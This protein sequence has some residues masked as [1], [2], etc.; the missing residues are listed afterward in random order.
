M[1]G[2]A[3]WLGAQQR[4]NLAITLALALAPALVIGLIA[5]QLLRPLPDIAA[6]TFLPAT[7]RLGAVPPPL[8]W[9]TTGS[10]AVAVTGLGTIGTHGPQT[11]LPLASTAKVMTALVVLAD[12]PLRLTEQGPTVPVSAADVATYVAEK[13]QGQSVFPVAAGEKLS[14][15]QALQAL[16]VPSG[17]NIAELLAAWD[18]GSVGAFVDKMNARAATL[19]LLHTHYVDASGLSPQSVGTPEEL[20]A[21]AEAA[22]QDPV[23]AEIVAQPEATLPVAGRVFNV[24]AV[25]GQDGIVGV[26]TGSS[27]AAGACFVFAAD[28]RADGQPAR[29]FGAILGLPTLDDAFTSATSLVQAVGSALH[30]RSVLSTN[31]V[32]AEYAAPWGD[33][34]TVFAEQDVNWIAYDGMVLRQ[35]TD[36]I[37]VRAPLP[38]GSRV[39]T[40]TLELGEQRTQ[41]PLKT[42]EP[43]FQPDSV[44]RL[45]RVRLDRLFQ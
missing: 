20:I 2:L 30:Y 6:T 36:I 13:N 7:S 23:F 35:R 34:A 28:V 44:W 31:Q 1:K 16:L 12:R 4:R 17:N 9:P 10:A 18:A 45:T 39:G 32:I 19:Q 11:S 38:S 29:L 33:S 22:L 15:Y 5:F 26:K 37:R 43:I 3:V 25:V 40:L 27:G 42:T 41:L 24:D 8:P 14:E 21:L